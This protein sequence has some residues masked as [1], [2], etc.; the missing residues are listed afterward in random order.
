MNHKKQLTIF[1][2]FLSLSLFSQ[3][4]T[5]WYGS[6]SGELPAM[7]LAGQNIV[8]QQLNLNFGYQYSSNLSVFLAGGTGLTG[9][10]SVTT[11][12]IRQPT[13]LGIGAD[14]M[15]NIGNNSKLGLE[16]IVQSGTNKGNSTNPNYYDFLNYQGGIK[17]ESN[18]IY[19]VIGIRNRDFYVNNTSNLELYYG[20]GYKIHF[21]TKRK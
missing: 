15:F 21:T 19:A 5:K 7:H 13:L 9:E 20:L 12:Y 17:I 2:L 14:Y 3:E 6:F 16:L 8:S 4:K 18:N 10:N 11:E 1:L